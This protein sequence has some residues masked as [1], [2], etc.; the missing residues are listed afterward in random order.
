MRVA[1]TGRLEAV[2]KVDVGAEISGRVLALHTDFG[3][4]VAQGDLLARLSTDELDARRI[5]SDAQ[6]LAAQAD[7]ARAEADLVDAERA[8][9]RARALALTKHVS[10]AHV[11]ELQTTMDR[12]GAGLSAAKARVSIASAALSVVNASIAKAQIRS[13][14]DGIV[15]NR[16][17]EIGQTVT[18]GF[19]TPLMFTLASDLNRLELK[20]DID[21]ADIGQIAP[22]LSALFSV[23]AFPDRRFRARIEAVRPAPKASPNTEQARHDVVVYEAILSVDNG[24]A[25]LR[26]GLTAAVDIEIESIEDAL[27]I[28]NTALR[29]SPPGTTNDIASAVSEEP[30]SGRAYVLDSD[31][32]AAARDLRLG[33][34]DGEFTQILQGDLRRGDEVLIGVVAESE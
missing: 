33:V 9:E 4:R 3:Q 1:A 27:Q 15:L 34:T 29:Y 21:E 28:E 8:V 5:E 17:V 13:P 26:P 16:S 11:D 25:L 22:G 31:G 30:L 24:D 14:I 10:Q 32:R 23:D 19:Q 18:A 12:A 2:G 6:L 7:V 20:A